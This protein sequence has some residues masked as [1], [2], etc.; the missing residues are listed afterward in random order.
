MLQQIL[1]SVKALKSSSPDD[2]ISALT[3]DQG[4]AR[5]PEPRS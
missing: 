1:R 3:K 5:V 4:V 2:F